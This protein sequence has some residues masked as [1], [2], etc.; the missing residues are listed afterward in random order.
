[1]HFLSDDL[2][3][4]I[5]E[6]LLG[7]IGKQDNEEQSSDTLFKLLCQIYLHPKNE[8]FKLIPHFSSPVFAA[9]QA[10]NVEF[11]TEIASPPPEFV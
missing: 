4:Y 5:F 6:E 1:M 10:V 8:D 7:G 11:F 9:Y 2:E 3:N